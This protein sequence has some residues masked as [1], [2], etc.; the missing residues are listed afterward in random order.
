MTSDDDSDTLFNLADFTTPTEADSEPITVSDALECYEEGLDIPALDE[1]IGKQLHA[2]ARVTRKS[3]PWRRFQENDWF[4]IRHPESD[5]TMVVSIM[6]HA[7]QNIAIQLY[8][9]SEGIRFWNDI[10]DTGSVDESFLQYHLRMIEC[11]FVDREHLEKSDL[12]AHKQFSQSS[13][14]RRHHAYPLFRSYLPG[15]VPWPIDSSEAE[16]IAIA[17]RLLPDFEAH[18]QAEGEKY[19]HSASVNRPPIPLFSLKKDGDVKIASDWEISSCQFPDA[20]P[21]PL[22]KAPRDDLFA[23]RLEG[24]EIVPSSA[25]WECGTFPMPDTVLH[26]GRIAFTTVTLTHTG[27]AMVGMPVV[28]MADECPITQIRRSFAESADAAQF[29]PARLRFTDP[30]VE[31]ALREVAAARGIGLE[32]VDAL[33][34]VNE[35]LQLINQGQD[36][37]RESA[38]EAL[39]PLPPE[40]L[41]LLPP[42]II[43][44]LE[45]APPETI[46][47]FFEHITTLLQEEAS[48]DEPLPEPEYRQPT[49]SERFTIRIELVGSEPKIWRRITMPTDACL[50]DLHCAIEGTMNWDDDHLHEFGFLQGKSLKPFEW[51]EE[52]SITLT[53]IARTKK[54]E[55]HYIYD[56]GDNWDHLIVIEGKPEPAASKKS[57]AKPNTKPKMI[58]GEGIAPMEDCGGIWGWQEFLAGSHPFLDDWEEGEHEK[59]LQQTFDPKKVRFGDAAKEVG[60]FV[61]RNS[62]R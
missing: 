30:L 37:A 47:Q 22:P 11:E 57:K 23:A 25:A 29:L 12:R 36:K 14:G 24:F 13:V 26:E 31:V 9:P 58:D 20:D 18:L 8:L 59:F 52:L 6:G 41:E 15:Y 32:Q 56:F 49:S 54:R 46:K 19:D 21:K 7:R 33:A 53:Q 48:E 61:S 35:L 38:R 3:E 27:G 50:F 51:H 42:E 45:N 40:V 43:T 60:Y 2:L 5:E 16:L 17:L 10:L 44:N 55:F 34:G 28:V 39:N 1:A 4:G 62:Q